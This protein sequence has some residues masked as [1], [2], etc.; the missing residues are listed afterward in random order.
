MKS[1]FFPAKARE[2]QLDIDS[3]EALA[4]F[5]DRLSLL[6]QIAEVDSWTIS[7]SSTANHWHVRVF[8]KRKMS[9]LARIALQAALGSDPIREMIN[10]GRVL[11]GAPFPI[12]LFERFDPVDE[13]TTQRIHS[14]KVLS[15]RE[16]N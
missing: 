3:A 14:F 10:V 1:S 4:N 6:E 7:E 8:L 13:L 15:E 12:V 16:G 2:L 11:R 9:T 5:R